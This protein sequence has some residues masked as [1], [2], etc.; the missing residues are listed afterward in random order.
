LVAWASERAEVLISPL[1]NRWLHVQGVV[2]S[3]FWVGHTLKEE[4]CLLLLAVAYL[5]DIGYVLSLRVTGFHPL[6]AALYVR[7]FG[8]ER[9]VSLIAHHLAVKLSF[10]FCGYWRPGVLTF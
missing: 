9:L 1:G 7:S 3:T 10:Q 8:Y 4:D 6:D 5:H 2:Q